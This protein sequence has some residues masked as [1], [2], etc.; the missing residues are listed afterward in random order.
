MMTN[1]TFLGFILSFVTAFG[2][3]QSEPF[4]CDFNAYLFQYND[5]YTIDLAS[6]SSYLVKENIVADKINGAAY[7][8]ADGYLWGYLGN[9]SIVRIGKDFETETYT[10]P[11]IPVTGMNYVGDIDLFG[12]YF[13]RAGNS[14]YYHVDLNPDSPNYLKYQ[15][16]STLNKSIK[17]HDWAFNAADNMLYTVEKNSNKLYRIEVE[18]GEVEDLG[19]VPILNGNKYTYGAVYFDV[20][21]N[22]Y[23]SANQ[24]GTV[25]IIK[26]VQNIVAGGAMESNLFAFGPAAA[27]NDGARCP[28]APVPQEDCRNGVDDDGDGLVDCDD[29]ACSGVA[30]CPVIRPTSSG[31]NG[32]LESNDRLSSLI[33]KRNYERVKTNYQFDK[34]AAKKVTKKNNYYAKGKFNPNAIPLS[35]LVPLDVIGETSVIESAPTD[36]LELTNASDIYSVDY[37]NG[38]ENIGT[39]MVI[40]T[41]NQVYEHSKFICDRFLGAQLLNVSTLYLREEQPFIKSI[42]KQAD[43][44]TE[45]ALSFSARLDEASEFVVE[46]HWNID[47]YEQNAAYYNFQ[48]WA[49]NID[50]LLALGEELLNLLES[51]GAINSYRGS[52]PPPVFV[53]SA[54]YNN[55]KVMLRVINNNKTQNIQISGGV[56]ATETSVSNSVSFQA[57]LS[58]YLEEIDLATGTLFDFGFRISDDKDSTPDDLFVADAP[59]GLDDSS[60]GTQIASYEVMPSAN[61]YTGNGYPIERNVMVSGAT[62]TYMGV[63][64]AMTPRFASVD[65]SEYSYLAFEASGIGELE[66][67]LIKGDGTKL[68][69]HVELGAEAKKFELGDAEFEGSSSTGAFEDIKVITFNMHAKSGAQETKQLNLSSVEFTNESTVAEPSFILEN[70][71]KSIVSPNPMTSE[72]QLYFFEERAAEYTLALYDINGRRVHTATMSGSTTAGQNSITLRKDNLKPGFYLYKLSSSNKKIWSGKLLVK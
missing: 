21:G 12:Q 49:G 19:V 28:S 30:A 9:K 57:G 52:A 44:S 65:L 48:V 38:S 25:Y 39:L 31:N 1:K 35:D 14:T 15:G 63:Y 51:N 46:S 10:I 6:G 22:F 2:Y 33:N 54:S 27:S 34:F 7:N 5:I 42:I 8:S 58:E 56:K 18:T 47:K 20:D 32:G 37:L 3:S 64:R 62:N 40:K 71:N 36:L 11:E 55:G 23:V 60:E 68:S 17:I 50:D 69:S 66:I 16:S 29:P 45:Y 41:D 70:T 72:A 13:F 43:G 4:D 26:A 67:V 59:W 24:T 61:V 53:R